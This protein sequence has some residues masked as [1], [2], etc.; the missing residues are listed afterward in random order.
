MS[1]AVFPAAGFIAMAIEGA[2]SIH[3]E[4]Q[5]PLKI[6][7]YVLRKI[8]IKTALRFPEDDSGVEIIF[9]MET[10]EQMSATSPALF[11]FTISS[12]SRDSSEWT[13]H[14]TGLVKVEVSKSAKLEKMNAVM[15]ARFPD[16][17]AWYKKFADIGLGYGPTFQPLSRL[18]TD[19]TQNLAEA[20]VALNTTNGIIE[21]GESSYI[22]RKLPHNLSVFAH[23]GIYVPVLFRVS[24][25]L[26][27][28]PN[29]RNDRSITD[30]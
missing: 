2:T 5:D 9:S 25:A 23:C 30:S 13:E 6:T 12:V 26:L 3:T 21:G 20:E 16:V 29:N 14:C 7:G 4:L 15:D 27:S 11:H 10:T 17:A 24:L 22:I 28:I 1:D 19:P 18:R 8:D